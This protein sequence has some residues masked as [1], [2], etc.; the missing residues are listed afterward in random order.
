M[1]KVLDITLYMSE[2]IYDFQNK[3]FIMGR[4][5]GSDDKDPEYASNI[6]ASDDEEDRNQAVRSIQGA[7][8]ELLNVLSEMLYGKT[9]ATSS[10]KLLADSDIKISLSVPSNFVMGI[11]DSIASSIHDYIVNKAL[12]GWF[13]MT[14]KDDA[15]EYSELANAA[16]ATLRSSLNKRERPTRKNIG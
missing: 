7:Y 8:G 4:S 3:A 9:E 6:K 10:N 5:K 11:K 2:L 15:R 12:L 1:S 16:L 14:D 13:L